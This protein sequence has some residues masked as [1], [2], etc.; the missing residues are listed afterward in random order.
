MKNKLTGILFLMIIGSSVFFYACKKGV[1]NELE[2]IAKQ[3]T[4]FYDQN[5]TTVSYTNISLEND[6][7]AFGNLATFELTCDQLDSLE[8]DSILLQWEQHYSGYTSM[9]KYW[10]QFESTSLD[11]PDYFAG[12]CDDVALGTVINADG[13]VKI[14]TIAYLLDFADTC[15]Y[16]VYPVT[17]ANIALLKEKNEIN[18]D[19]MYIMRYSINEE[20]LYPRGYEQV[21]ELRMH[22]GQ[23]QR[24]DAKRGFKRFMRKVFHAFGDC[25]DR[26][27]ISPPIDDDESQ[28][29]D[30]NNSSNKYRYI[31]KIKY[32]SSG[33]R[34]NVIAKCKHS[35]KVGEG[36]WKREKGTSCFVGEVKMKV[37]CTVGEKYA[38]PT[39]YEDLPPLPPTLPGPDF[40][41]SVRWHKSFY[42]SGKRLNRIK[43]YGNFRMENVSNLYLISQP[44]RSMS[45]EENPLI[46]W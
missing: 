35:K 25:E 31:Y 44:S 21:E 24:V 12:K 22:N 39:Y 27:H 16:E 3:G 14:D 1:K 42:H 28:F 40:I 45:V 2:E 34:F 18:N 38:N 10:E 4:I 6:Y 19:T 9:R 26:K 43:Y 8:H 29:T 23:T 33:L 20:I 30:V 11:D 15:V 46:S 7:L 41:T 32:Q 13:I 5:L 36:R 17:P 37:F